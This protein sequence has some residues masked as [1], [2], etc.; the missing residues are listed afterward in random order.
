MTRARIGARIG[1]QTKITRRRAAL[2]QAWHPAFAPRDQ[3]TAAAP[4]RP[5]PG[6]ALY[7]RRDRSPTGHGRGPRPAA[8]HHRGDEPAPGRAEFARAGA[9]GAQAGVRLAQPGWPLAD[10]RTRPATITPLPLP[11]PLP[12]NAPERN[13]VETLWRDRRAN[14]LSTRLFRSYED[15]PDQCCHAGNQLTN[16]PWA[17]MSIGLRDWAYRL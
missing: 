2:G 13:P 9:P 7:R 1:Q 12:P 5:A 6:P 4:A 16:R 3:R 17:I 15:I 10:N 14:W 8:L 11:L